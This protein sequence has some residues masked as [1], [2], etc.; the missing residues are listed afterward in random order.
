MKLDIISDSWQ[1]S[2]KSEN[3]IVDI[4]GLSNRVF[5]YK[6]LYMSESVHSFGRTGHPVELIFEIISDKLN[7][8]YF[9][10]ETRSISFFENKVNQLLGLKCY[11]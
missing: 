6:I 5:I 10:D 7:I 1:T 11:M 3:F 2:I 8:D 4:F 9:V